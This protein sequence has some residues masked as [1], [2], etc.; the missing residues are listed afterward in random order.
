MLT[1]ANVDEEILMLKE[2][3]EQTAAKHNFNFQ[4]PDVISLS[5]Q[6]DKLIT[7]VMRNKW[8]GQVNI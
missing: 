6:L 7:L 8:H 2:Q 1:Q 4:H 3:L 5:Q